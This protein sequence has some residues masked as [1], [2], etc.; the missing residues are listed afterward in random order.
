MGI[1]MFYC[2]LWLILLFF[3]TISILCSEYIFMNT[4]IPE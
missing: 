4:E 1:H 2:D 3:N